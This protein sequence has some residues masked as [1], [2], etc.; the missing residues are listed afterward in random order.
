[1][2]A[3]LAAPRIEVRCRSLLVISKPPGLSLFNR[4]RRSDGGRY[5]A[6]TREPTSP[7][8]QVVEVA[9]VSLKFQA[10]TVEDGS[11]IVFSPKKRM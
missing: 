1:M 10:Y 5:T 8:R 6:K 9:K 4:S 7:N 11:Q 3:E 2:L